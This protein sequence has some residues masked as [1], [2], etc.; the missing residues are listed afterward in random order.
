MSVI[1]SFFLQERVALH[2]GSC[3]DQSS[4]QSY[5][6][7]F[8]CD[9]SGCQ[10]SLTH[11]QCYQT[12][13]SAHFPSW[14]NIYLGTL[15]KLSEYGWSLPAIGIL[16][17]I[18]RKDS[19]S[20]VERGNISS[21]MY[22]A[23]S[24]FILSFDVGAIT[25]YW[26]E[27]FSCLNGCSFMSLRCFAMSFMCPCCHSKCFFKWCYKRWRAAASLAKVCTSSSGYF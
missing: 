11:T 23:T 1:L 5:L 6:C 27:S 4:E 20:T 25:F 16:L 8:R 26:N 15:Q 3:L 13:S 12:F 7:S 18:F 2:D 21:A 19:D 17:S 22:E 10:R 24:L 14:R 9:K